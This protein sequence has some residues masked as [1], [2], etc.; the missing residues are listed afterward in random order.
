MLTKTSDALR[1]MGALLTLLTFLIILSFSVQA[2]L[3]EPVPHKPRSHQRDP[4]SI[5]QPGEGRPSRPVVEAV[6]TLD[7]LNQELNPALDG[8]DGST[9]G[10][11]V[12][13]ASTDDIQRRPASQP[14]FKDLF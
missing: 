2:E 10:E 5:Y 1:C 14:P 3:L 8:F 4:A 7:T 11:P 13:E 6:E 9:T 12:G